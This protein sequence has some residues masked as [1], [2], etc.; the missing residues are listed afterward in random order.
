MSIYIA[1]LRETMPPLNALVSIM[2]D[3]RYAFSSAA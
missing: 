1:R 2:S 3:G